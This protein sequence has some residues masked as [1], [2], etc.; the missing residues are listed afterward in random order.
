MY[1]VFKWLPFYIIYALR[2]LDFFFP[3]CT[4]K[5]AWFCVYKQTKI[6]NNIK[7]NDGRCAVCVHGEALVLH[8]VLW[9]QE[10]QC[11]AGRAVLCCTQA[12][13][14]QKGISIAWLCCSLQQVE[15]LLPS[16]QR[17]VFGGEFFP[18]PS[19]LNQSKR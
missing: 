13:S 6:G 7:N 16:L 4:V 11:P 2:F 14:G 3:P 17:R 8:W 12:G 9:V 19:K 15:M 10:L 1:L 18:F 5:L